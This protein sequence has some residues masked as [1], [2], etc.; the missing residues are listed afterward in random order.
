VSGVHGQ[1]PKPLL[2]IVVDVVAFLV[3]D[4]DEFPIDLGDCLKNGRCNVQCIVCSGYGKN[5]AKGWRGR[6]LLATVGFAFI[7][8][9]SRIAFTS[10]FCNM[11]MVLAA[12]Q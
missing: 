10:F 4:L 1:F 12:S 5:N 11:V 8:A 7:E 9:V 3:G 6:W 2:D